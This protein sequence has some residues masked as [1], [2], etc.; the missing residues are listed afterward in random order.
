M[1]V[2]SER[3]VDE[4]RPLLALAVGGHL[5][6]N[7]GDERVLADRAVQDVLLGLEARALVHGVRALALVVAIVEV[8]LLDGPASSGLFFM[9]LCVGLAQRRVVG[10]VGILD[11]HR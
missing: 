6:R 9:D 3:L 11:L 2:C 5:R 10:V 4:L 7:V 8:L 1:R